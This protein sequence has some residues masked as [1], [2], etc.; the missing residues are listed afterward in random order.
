MKCLLT[1]GLSSMTRAQV[2]HVVDACMFARLVPRAYSLRMARFTTCPRHD[3]RTTALTVSTIA[4][5]L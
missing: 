2:F 3:R 4:R 1:L 5:P